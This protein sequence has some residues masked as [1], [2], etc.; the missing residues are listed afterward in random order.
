MK[1]AKLIILYIFLVSSMSL[2]GQVTLIAPTEK[3]NTGDLISAEIKVKSR[4]TIAGL[5]FS[6]L[7]DPTILSF[8]KVTNFNLTASSFDTF[9]ITNVSKGTL[10]L[11]WTGVDPFAIKD[12]IIVFKVNFKVVG[13]KGTSSPITFSNPKAYDNTLNAAPIPVTAKNG[14]IMVNSS[15]SAIEKVS[16]TEG[17][18]QLYQ[19]QPNPCDNKIRIPFT[20]KEA[21]EVTLTIY[22]M[23]GKSLYSQKKKV[24]AGDQ[25]FE[26]NTEGVLLKGMYIYGIQ[27]R[28]GF[29][30]RTFTKI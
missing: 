21:D 22:D 28:K 5:E 17:Y 26:L 27:T 23:L 30:S 7:W 3:A 1:Q 10:K 6:L 14:A 18:A 16:D 4:D 11:L 24:D 20:I 15:T 2:N 9:G 12:S 8:Q 29:I 19:S 25:N 13:N